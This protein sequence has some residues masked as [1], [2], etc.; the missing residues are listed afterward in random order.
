MRVILIAEDFQQEMQKLSEGKWE[1]G[2]VR[3][4]I[5]NKDIYITA[6]KTKVKHIILSWDHTVD[7][8]IKV[9]GDHWERG[10]GDLYWGNIDYDRVMPWYILLYDGGTTRCYGVKTRPNAFCSWRLTGH[11]ITLNLDIRCGGC[12]VDLKGRTLHAATVLKYKSNENPFRVA[13]EF[14]RL[15]CPDGIYPKTPVYGGNDWYCNYGDNSHDK[16][17]HMAKRIAKWAEGN[18]VRPF[19]VVDDGW[20]VCHNGQEGFNGGPW[21]KGNYKFPDM[22]KLA[23]DIRALDVQPG[24]WYR[25]LFTAEKFPSDCIL[26]RRDADWQYLDPSHPKVL[27]QVKKDVSRIKDWGYALLKHDFSTFDIFGRWGFAMGDEMTEEGW[28]FYDTGKTTAE[29]IKEFYRTIREAAGDMLLIGCNTVSH[30]SAGYFEIQRTGDDTSGLDWAR[31]RKMGINSLAFRMPQHNLFYACD[32]DCVGL[33]KQ[34]EW[35]YNR[36]WLELLAKSGTPLFVSV[37]ED[38]TEEEVETELRRAFQ[39]AAQQPALGTPVDWLYN[40]TPEKWTLCGE[41]IEFK[42]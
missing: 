12:G 23:A 32:G 25:P 29:I 41:T 39:I 16:I 36:Q 6:E 5:I 38:V 26:K 33:T 1:A 9:L 11:S 13:R 31:T 34:V 22:R 3:V 4:E 14:C 19:M 30:L 28:A 2:D 18:E 35:K 42:W 37:A 24:I 17:L 15:M 40:L 20:Q 21:D 7:Q 8:E 27:Q 10:Y